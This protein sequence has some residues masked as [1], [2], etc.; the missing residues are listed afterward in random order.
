M[1]QQGRAAVT[2]IRKTKTPKS[3]KKKLPSD[4][5]LLFVLIACAMAAAG[6]EESVE[7]Y[8]CA[9]CLSLP[10]RPV[11]T[12]CK[13]TFCD[14]CWMRVARACSEERR[15]PSCPTCRTVLTQQAPQWNQKLENL[16]IARYPTEWSRLEAAAGA[17]ARL[18]T[19]LAAERAKAGAVDEALAAEEREAEELT[20]PDGRVSRRMTRGVIQRCASEQSQYRTLRLTARLE[21]SLSGL[22]DLSPCLAELEMLGTLH[23]QHNLI[24]SLEHLRLP[25]LKVLVLHHNRLGSLSGLSGAP[26]LIS[27]DVG[28]NELRTLEGVQGCTSLS[29]C[30]AP[31]NRFDGADG[32]RPLAQCAALS[33]LELHD[34]ALATL[35]DLAPLS[36]LGGLRTL[37]L[38]GNPL[39][40][41]GRKAVLQALPQVRLLDGAPNAEAERDERRRA[42]EARQASQ[43]RSNAAMQERKRLALERRA[44][45]AAEAGEAPPPAAAGGATSQDVGSSSS[46]AGADA[47]RESP[48]T[49]PCAAALQPASRAAASAPY[50]AADAD[51]LAS[52]AES[53]EEAAKVAEVAKPESAEEAAKVAE[54]VKP[55]SAEEAAKVAEVAELE[56][57]QLVEELGQA[58]G[59]EAEAA[60]R[61]EAVTKA[62]DEA[63]RGGRSEPPAA[64]APLGPAGCCYSAALLPPRPLAEDR[65][66][67]RIKWTEEAD[68]MLARVLRL[69]SFR[70]EEAAADFKA[71]A[72]AR[73]QAHVGTGQWAAAASWQVTAKLLTAEQCRLRWA[74]LDRA[75]CTPAPSP[76]TSR[77][78]RMSRKRL[79]MTHRR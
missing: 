78:A 68:A 6:E 35:D 58:D 39:E 55:E 43:S 10:Y 72:R 69:R 50:L 20:L 31:S 14:A 29:S 60:G 34:N 1:P 22:R 67:W 64:A 79:A 21:L 52:A 66:D 28:H 57:I 40:A 19:K 45:A 12:A 2:A 62:W 56:E 63:E 74:A 27:L 7:E 44:A 36:A 71:Q 76:R 48:P 23:L 25:Q 32:L 46:T 38:R 8:T 4:T 65:C 17:E 15:P 47:R 73:A 77:R 41:T 9:I 59:E 5:R 26:A 51:P 70:F 16:L 11:T 53:A 42:L 13:H 18:Q 3:E 30:A 49:S 61:P 75:M 37:K 33:A 54:V 24:A